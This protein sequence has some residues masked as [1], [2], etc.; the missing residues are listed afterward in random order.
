MAAA[1]GGLLTGKRLQCGGNNM[2][3]FRHAK[4]CGSGAAALTNINHIVQ[5]LTIGSS[6]LR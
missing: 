1:W 6:I 4:L 5:I 3:H 2:L